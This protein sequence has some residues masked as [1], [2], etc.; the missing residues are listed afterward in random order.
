MEVFEVHIT[1]D[2][3]IHEAA[4]KYG[5]KTIAVELLRPDGTVLRTEHMTSQVMRFPSYDEC[6]QKVLDIRDELA[7]WCA[8]W[9]VKVECPVYDH[10]LDRSLY[11]E[12]HFETKNNL[13]PISRNKNKVTWMGT[14]RTYD[15]TEYETFQTRWHGEI[16]ELALYDSN[17]QE[18]WDW[19]DLWPLR[20]PVLDY[21][22]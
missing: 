1:G 18:D 14:D 9:R 8:I 21:C 22:I 19:L 17:I 20:E 13:F 3:R 11:L 10:Y 2:E 4:K 16:L 6:I 7:R 5:L 15:H 12:S